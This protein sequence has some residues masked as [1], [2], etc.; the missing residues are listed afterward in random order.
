M[1]YRI[2]QELVHNTL[3]HANAKNIKLHMKTQEDILEIDYSDDGKG[4][5]YVDKIDS[6]SIGLTSIRSRVDFLN[7]NLEVTSE[8]GKGVS[9]HFSIPC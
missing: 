4:F 1:V 2:I 5:N 7:G 6:K 8:S 3:K 9:F